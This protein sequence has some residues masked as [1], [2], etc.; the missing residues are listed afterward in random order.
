MQ[1]DDIAKKLGELVEARSRRLALASA[2]W[3]ARGL[4][5]Q[6]GG[7][8]IQ[9]ELK[10][11]A[12]EIAAAGQQEL[13]TVIKTAG[14]ALSCLASI[15]GTEE[16]PHFG[17]KLLV[18]DDSEITG[19]LVALAL[20]GVGCVVAFANTLEDFLQRLVDFMPDALIIEPGHPD[21]Q[22]RGAE[23]LRSRIERDVLP[24]ILF[25][26]KP[27]SELDAA[28]DALH[29]DVVISKDLGLAEMLHQVDEILGG[30]IW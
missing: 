4:D 22:G 17:R 23:R 1:P 13:A 12:G 30:I 16:P 24:V 27:R 10:G 11:L 5:D 8:T 2:I 18:M 15:A 14:D 19:D 26:A 3:G 29:A 6:S 28:A 7:R 21:L 9:A 20:E 25:S